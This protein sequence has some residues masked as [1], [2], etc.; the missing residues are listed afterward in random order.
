ME[1]HII[2]S[3]EIGSWW[4][5][6]SV[7]YVRFIL[8]R[9]KDKDVHVGFCSLGGYVSDGLEMMQA[10]RDHGKVHAHAFGMNASIS[11]VAM[12][13]CVSID[14]VKG[15]FFLIHNTSYS[16]SVWEQANKERIADIIKSLQKGQDELKT[17][18]DV[19]AQLY[20]DKTGKTVDECKAQ[21]TKGNWMSAQQA[22]EFGLV[23]SIRDDKAA[24]DK[25]ANYVQRFVNS[26]STNIDLKDAGIPP[27]DLGNGSPQKAAIADADGNPTQSFLAKTWQGLQNFIR[28]NHALNKQKRDMIVIFKALAA[29]LAV[30]SF[31]PDESGNVS[32]SQDQMKKV[33]DRLAEQEKTIRD[34]SDA[35]AKA[36]EK[37]KELKAKVAEQEEQI[38][39]L[40]G[41]APVTDNGGV[42]TGGNQ[43][44]TA[45]DL[46][47]AIKEV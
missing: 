32:L 47:E 38:K 37:V 5:G 26:Y 3:G 36:A 42:M 17:F 41:S 20:A 8:S 23:D 11:T 29:L 28:N 35:M 6:C 13:G 43:P 14:I 18:D 46:Y 25:A 33:D 44:F 30:E 16:V 2:I 12:L 9:N 27:L 40:Q 34:N 21:M 45:K 22:L 39:A 15:S 31:T 24:E 10:F 19:L 1:Y 7:D 4:S